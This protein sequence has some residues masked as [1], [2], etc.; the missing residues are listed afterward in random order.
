M[1]DCVFAVFR[2]NGPEDLKPL[3]RGCDAFLFVNWPDALDEACRMRPTDLKLS[4]ELGQRP[5]GPSQFDEPS[6]V[7]CIGATEP[8]G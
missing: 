6:A 1:C 8:A 2:G 5:A 7:D 4:A 3:V